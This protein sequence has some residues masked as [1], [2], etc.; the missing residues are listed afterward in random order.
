MRNIGFDLVL[1]LIASGC[2]RAADEA[3]LLPAAKYM[4]PGSCAAPSCHGGVQPRSETSVLQNE[5]STWVVKDKYHTKAYNVL[6]NDIAQR[7]GRILGLPHPETE[8]KCLL[9]HSLNASA[10]Q[11]ARTFDKNDG[12]SCENCHGPASNWL[13]PHTRRDWN[14]E[15][16]VELGMYNTRDL[17]KR[18]ER[19]LS[20]HLG[21]ADKL[22]DHAMIAAG[23]PDLYFEL[24][25]FQATMP[26]HW[27][28][29]FDKDPWVGVRT[30]GVG[31][32]VQLREELR[33]VAFRAQGS[34]WPEY[35][36]LDCFACHHSLT[37]AKD[38]WRQQRGYPDRRPGNPPFNMSR[39]VVFQKVAYEVDREAN[40]QLDAEMSRVYK[41]VS[42]ITGDRHQVTVT[43]NRAAN[44]AD[45][46]ARKIQGAQFDRDITL[47]LMKSISGD[48]ERISNQGER[49]AEQAF[50]ALQS[51]F[52][53][54]SGKEKL[55]NEDQLRQALNGLFQQFNDQ[56]AYNPAR[57]AGQLRNVNAL[58]R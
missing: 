58:L 21:T 31:Q 6:T 27:K 57:F 8:Q 45:R 35:A 33:R 37:A 47:R 48:A 3:H 32:A 13:E 39:Y 43:A 1:V 50:M 34:V 14:Y 20:C 5:Y 17:V 22:V 15:K 9:C 26:P 11:S 53:V 38:S 41:A 42:D 52:V 55:A 7:M 24:A 10:E 18:S 29:P 30:V 49:T 23:H 19:C 54:Y 56:S 28:E 2:L 25:S 51:L 44:I 46:L 36:E 4:G 40:Q 16:S 12:V